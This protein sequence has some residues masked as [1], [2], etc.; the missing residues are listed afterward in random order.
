[1]GHIWP[2]KAFY[3]ACIVI[4]KKKIKNIKVNTDCF[5]GSGMTMSNETTAALAVLI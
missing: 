1:M 4:Y 3:V 2:A 5:L